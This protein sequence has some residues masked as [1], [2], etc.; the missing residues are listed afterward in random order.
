MSDETPSEQPLLGRGQTVP[1]RRWTWLLPL[2]LSI[3]A[4][5]L[6]A[7]GVI[8]VTRD[9]S[10]SPQKVMDQYLDLVERGDSVKA[11]SLLCDQFRRDRPF[12]E[13]QSI[14]T[15]EKR[16]AG[17]VTDHR[18]GAVSKLPNGDR[19]VAYTVKRSD[20]QLILDARLV[21]ERGNWRV[22]GIR[23][24]GPA[25]TTTSTATSP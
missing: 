14:L 6:A 20:G 8:A 7:V 13:Y 21:R 4:V 24:R 19:A 2:L 1:R 9:T 12:N 23:T 17:G 11:Y 5:S 18:I 15:L 22:C 16:E 10:P 3:A 25:P